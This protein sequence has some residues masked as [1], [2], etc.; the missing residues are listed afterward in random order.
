ME[1]V[2]IGDVRFVKVVADIATRIIG[3]DLYLYQTLPSPSVS[4]GF[5]L[6]TGD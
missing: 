5:A 1:L 4:V 6:S 2:L 3:E